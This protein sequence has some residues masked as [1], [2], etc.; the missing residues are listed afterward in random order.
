[1]GRDILETLLSPPYGSR[2]HSNKFS[3]DHFHIVIDDMSQVSTNYWVSMTVI[4]PSVQS[5]VKGEREIGF[6]PPAGHPWTQYRV[7]W[8]LTQA[9]SQRQSS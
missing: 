3:Q 9:S 8:G 7:K 1:M 6:H 4:V 5:H 2:S